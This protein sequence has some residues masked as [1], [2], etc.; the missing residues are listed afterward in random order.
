MFGCLKFCT[1]TKKA[2]ETVPPPSTRKIKDGRKFIKS[3]HDG[4]GSINN[5]ELDC[6]LPKTP[7]KIPMPHCKLPKGGTGESKSARDMVMDE[8]YEEILQRLKNDN[9]DF[10]N[11]IIKK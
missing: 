3:Y 2:M 8:I 4:Y 1:S 11:K 5:S 7:C 10:K 9:K 6:L